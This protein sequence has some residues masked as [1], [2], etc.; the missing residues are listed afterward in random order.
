MRFAAVVALCLAPVLAC[1]LAPLP[2]GAAAPD[3]LVRK[4]A[5]TFDD[6]PWVPD[7][8]SSATGRAVLSDQVPPDA[9]PGKCMEIEV[10]FSG[11][12]FEHAAVAPAQPLVIPGRART[13]RLWYRATDKGYPLIVRFKDGWGRTEKRF[14]WAPPDADAGKWLAATFTVPEEWVRPITIAGLA[15]HNWSAQDA[16]KTVRFWVD[17]ME[18]ETDLADVDGETGLLKTWKPDPSPADAAKALKAPPA[19]P[20]VSVAVA[21]GQ[22]SNVFSREE[23]S[24]GISLRNWKPGAL[25]A[26][27]S[28][29]VLDSGGKEVDRRE[30]TVSVD[31]PVNLRV[32]LKVERFG[33]YTLETTLAMADGKRHTAKTTFAKVPPYADLTEAEKRASP[34]GVN[35]HGGGER[36]PVIPFKKAG[37]VWF[38][39]YAFTYEWMTRA[40]GADRRYAGW[41]WYPALVRRY[42]DA[43]VCLLPCLGKAIA[44]PP[45]KDGKPTGPGGP[46]R[47]W[48]REIADIV[49]A[50]P[51]VTHW[52]LDN[53]YELHNGAAAAETAIDWAN[54]RAYHRKFAEVVDLL[55]GG[56][57]VAVEQGR[58]GIWPDRIRACVAS[59]DFAKMGVVNTH[60]YCGTDAPEVNFGN[61]NTGFEGGVLS[62]PPMLFADRLRETKRA[63]VSDG[64]PRESWLTEF[65]WDTLAGPIVSPRQQAVYLARSWM[66]A[67]AAGTDKCFWF[68]DYDA[69]QPKQMFDGCG[70]LAA[71]ASPKLS[72]CAMAGLASALP[73]PAYVGSIDA[74]PGTAGFV[75]ESRGELV[76]ALWTIAGDDGPE[77]TFKAKQLRDWLGNPLPGKTV[78]LSMAP[79][80]AVGFEKADPRFAQTAYSLATP[81]LVLAAS[82][83]TVTADLEVANRRDAAIKA[84]VRLALPD[85]WTAERAEASIEV[86]PG[87]TKRL[88]VAFAINPAEELGEKEVRLAISEAGRE[89]R[90]IPLRVLVRPALAMLVGPIAGPP[91]EATVVVRIANKSARPIDGTLRLRLP[92]TWKAAPE[93]PVK[94]LKPGEIRDVACRITWTAEWKPGESARAEF[95]A[96][97]GRTIARPIIPPRLRLA[98]AKDIQV[99]GRLD[100]WPAAARLPDWTLGCSM[101]EARAT[102]RLAWAPE[103]LYGAVEVRGATLLQKD[104]RSFWAGDCLELFLDTRDEKRTRAYETGDHQ[105]WFFPLPDEK[106]VYVGR[107]KRGQEIA[108]TRYDIPGLATAVRRDGDGYVM[109]FLLPAAQ[110]QKYEPKAGSRLGVNLNLTVKGR[111]FD[112]EVYWPA[113]KAGDGVP[114]KPELWGTMELAP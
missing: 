33:L 68:Y 42:T 81:Q 58:A 16:A 61:W 18:V 27:F 104:P 77:V 64:R 30:Q 99:D 31:A 11:K 41:P 87:E 110:L 7:A 6:L 67:M 34:Y 106:R 46:D 48:V 65:G 69:P 14:E 108:E 45:M 86:A 85:G 3:T 22:V 84:D 39:D 72:L 24:V 2:C 55:G 103:G 8:W 35:V 23:P 54:Y 19:S 28:C 32:P 75:F 5:E 92:A 73:A 52:E 57:L 60:H 90:T 79:V 83:D 114:D 107:W 101:G 113:S 4:V 49:L 94:D 36:S 74:G 78:R 93:T 80:Y 47:A 37:L 15:T 12:G 98:R 44:L 62:Q 97:G 9:A 43:G 63:A 70:L 112:R 82:G 1:L 91:G 40:K 25:A 20:L 88:P 59:G 29:R 26:A 17:Q 102:F 95:D 66:V 76:A 109:E 100:D 50:F 10:G 21:T 111:Q 105:F 71:D 13:V 89:V 56:Q 38:R 96:G 53:E 51:Q